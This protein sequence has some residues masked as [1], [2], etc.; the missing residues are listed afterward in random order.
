MIH[1]KIGILFGR[2]KPHQ[3]PKPK[4]SFLGILF[5]TVGECLRCYSPI[6]QK[7][8]GLHHNVQKKAEN[9]ATK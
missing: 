9:T 6:F 7:Y 3:P 8:K 5:L 4:F 2:Q 1:L